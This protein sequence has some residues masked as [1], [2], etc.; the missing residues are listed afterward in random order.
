[1]NRYVQA[2]KNGGRLSAKYMAEAAIIL[3][4]LYLI[5]HFFGFR[6]YATFLTGTVADVGSP[7]IGA[8]LGLIYVMLYF[9]TVVLS[10]I[11]VIAAAITW[12][13]RLVRSL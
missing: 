12:A 9:A 11:L 4:V 5:L 10:P 2:W 8:F 7:M 1:M 6:S 3:T 13:V